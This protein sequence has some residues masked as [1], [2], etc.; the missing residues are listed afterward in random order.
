MEN[1][2]KKLWGDLYKSS[3]VPN[4]MRSGVSQENEPVRT[5]EHDDYVNT[6]AFS[7]DNEWVAS[8]GRDKKI[9]V[10]NLKTGVGCIWWP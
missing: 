2:E 10:R 8:G 3:E 4:P 1:E 9:I 5:I 6:C 7:P